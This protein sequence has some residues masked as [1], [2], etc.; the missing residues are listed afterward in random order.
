MYTQLATE[1]SGELPMTSPN[2][3]LHRPPSPE[4]VHNLGR[5]LRRVGAAGRWGV[6][7]VHTLPSASVIRPIAEFAG[8]GSGRCAARLSGAGRCG[9]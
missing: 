3:V 6:G 8:S 9:G 4:D 1:G 7:V 2:D 5:L